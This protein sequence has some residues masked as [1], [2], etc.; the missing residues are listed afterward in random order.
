MADKELNLDNFDGMSE[1]TQK[2]NELIKTDKNDITSVKIEDGRTQI[3]I[4][5]DN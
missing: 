4:E 1:A 3:V 5:E 2:A